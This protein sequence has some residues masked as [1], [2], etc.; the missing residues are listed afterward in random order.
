[1]EKEKQDA[2]KLSKENLEMLR[3]QAIRLLKQGRKQVEVAEILGVRAASI[4]DWWKIYRTHGNKGLKLRNP[5]PAKGTNRMLSP[6]QEKEIQRL[7]IDKTPDQLKLPFALWDRKA[8]R[9]LIINLYG[10]KVAIRTMGEYLHRWNFTPQRPLKRAYEQRPQE[11]KRWLAEEYPVIMHRAKQEGAE[12]QWG[13]ETGMR[14]DSHYG[15]GYSPK[16]KTPVIN[17]SARRVSINMISSITNRGKVRFMMYRKNMNADVL[18]KFLK[19]L[20]KGNDRKIFLILDNLRVHHAH[21]VRDWLDKRKD[22]IE[23]FYLPAYSPEINPDEYLNC[24]LKTSVHSQSPARTQD[25]LTSKVTSFMRKLQK[26]PSRVSNYFKHP[27]IA[28]AA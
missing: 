3:N 17:L 7:I 28:Y 12:I 26:S 2:R 6:D 13:D 5:G 20:I 18:I 8:I 10:I 11:V 23:V 1:M 15:R 24:D 16:G 21:V 22:Q 4:S 25:D 14:N 27:K 9:E 19:R